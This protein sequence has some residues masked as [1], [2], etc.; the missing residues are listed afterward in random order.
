MWD[1]LDSPPEVLALSLLVD[2][3]IVHPSGG[4]VASPGHGGMGEP[5]IVPEI[6]VGFC[7]I[8]GDED[9][10]VLIG[11]H[12]PRINVDIRIHFLKC[13]CQASRFHESANGG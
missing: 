5:F 2:D 10:T 13:N 4:K 11:A 12:G 3:R 6:Q 7:S 8:L 1:Y 9:L